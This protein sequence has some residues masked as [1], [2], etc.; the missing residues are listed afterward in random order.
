MNPSELTG[1]GCLLGPA[2]RK[3]LPSDSSSDARFLPS[4]ACSRQDILGSNSRL[5]VDTA[6]EEDTD[7]LWTLAEGVAL[8]RGCA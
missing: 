7:V 2:R 5:D 3:Q 6:D 1:S 4:F 8:F